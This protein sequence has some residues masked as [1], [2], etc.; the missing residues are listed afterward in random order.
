MVAGITYNPEYDLPERL[1][2][3]GAD[4]GMCFDE[5]CQ[6]FRSTGPFAAIRDGLQLGVG[7][8]SSTLNRH[9]IELIIVD[10]AGHIVEFNVRRLWDEHEVADALATVDRNAADLP[11]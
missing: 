5:R 7:Y 1:R 9:R 6:L 11:R 8:G 3:Y 4:R 2:R 10:P